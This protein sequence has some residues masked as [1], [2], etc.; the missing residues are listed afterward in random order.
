M[1]TIPLLENIKKFIVNPI[2]TL[3]I[4][5]GLVVFLWGLV[6]F[7][8]GANNEEKRSA[9]KQHMIWGVIGL[10]IMISAFGIMNII[11]GT[12]GAC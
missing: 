8:M 4:V 1:E 7:M 12:I 10:F 9:G 6:E 11:C 3:L 5:V 2:L